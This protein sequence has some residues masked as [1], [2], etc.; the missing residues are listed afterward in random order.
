MH[1]SA[2]PSL[3]RTVIYGIILRFL[4]FG[5]LSAVAIQK[6]SLYFMPCA[7]N[8]RIKHKGEVS[9]VDMEKIIVCKTKMYS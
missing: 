3:L 7:H 2:T 8:K 5:L 1:L 6:S 4:L 9:A